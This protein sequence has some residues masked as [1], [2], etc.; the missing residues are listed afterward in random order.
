MWSCRLTPRAVMPPDTICS[1]MTLHCFTSRLGV[2]GFLYTGF[3]QHRGNAG[4]FDVL[5]ALRFLNSNIGV[6]GGNNSTITLFGGGAGA[7]IVS[8]FLMSTLGRDLFR[9]A[10]L[11][12]IS[13]FLQ[14]IS[15]FSLFLVSLFLQVMYLFSGNVAIFR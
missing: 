9:N 3:P 8:T 6:F 5:T 13:F 7:Y 2:F 15:L 1:H 11:Q 4:L 14:V 12:V 10:I